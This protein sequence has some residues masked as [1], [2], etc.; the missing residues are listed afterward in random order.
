M[1]QTI[2]GLGGLLSDPSCCVLKDG[3]I[4]AAVEQAKV[5]RHDRPGNFPDEAFQRALDVAGIKP[6]AIDCIAVALSA[7]RPIAELRQPLDVRLVS[8]QF[9]AGHDGSRRFR[10]RIRCLR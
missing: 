10:R 9:K 6:E 7:L 5:S 2:V 8:F 1:P 3:R 4:A